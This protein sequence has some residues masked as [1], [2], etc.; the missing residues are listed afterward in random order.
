M[1]KGR[2]IGRKGQTL[3]AIIT[4]LILAFTFGI[5]MSFKP[6]NPTGSYWIALSDILLMELVMGALIIFGLRGSSLGAGKSSSR[7]MD[8][9]I[10]S[11]AGLSFSI[12]F[13]GDLLFLFIAKGEI[14][15][16]IFLWAAIGKWL[17]LAALVLIMG[18]VGRDERL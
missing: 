4:F 6:E 12:A 3:G 11:L 1:E 5:F 2:D 16:K 10:G 18:L 9:S 14:W 7:V 13:V 8:I 17:V 15:Q